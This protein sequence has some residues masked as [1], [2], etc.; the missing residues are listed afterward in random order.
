V[1]LSSKRRRSGLNVSCESRK[2]NSLQYRGVRAVRYERL[3][4]H[5]PRKTSL[6]QSVLPFKLDHES[7]FEI[8][9][10]LPHNFRIAALKYAVAPNFE[11][12]M[13]RLSPHCR[14]R[15]EVYQL[16]AEIALV[17]RYICIE[18]RRQSWIIPCCRLGVVVNEVHTRCGR[19][20][21]LPARRQRSEL[22][23]NLRL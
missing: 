23:G 2:K 16:L 13:S 8:V 11:L 6:I 20:S 18:R 7:L 22:R 14:L 17:L 12:A 15:T 5:K 4:R 9:G 19:K 3:S 1:R 10:R 21:R